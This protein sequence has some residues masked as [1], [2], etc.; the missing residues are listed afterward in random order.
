[1]SKQNLRCVQDC[2]NI[3][4][5]KFLTVKDIGNNKVNAKYSIQLK[6]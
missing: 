6:L 2:G 3:Y 5:V 1:M 4:D